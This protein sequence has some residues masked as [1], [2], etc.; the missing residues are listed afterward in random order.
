MLAVSGEA[1]EDSP[2][3]PVGDVAEGVCVEVEPVDPL[4]LLWGDLECCVGRH[5]DE[6]GYDG[7]DCSH[8][9]Y[10]LVGGESTLRC[11]VT[12]VRCVEVLWVH[13]GPFPLKG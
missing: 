4:L 1:S 8:G 2:L 5:C 7:E 3:G 13:F 9:V 10:C 6:Y 12:L 11:Q